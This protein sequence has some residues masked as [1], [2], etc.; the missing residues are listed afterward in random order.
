MAYRG[1][2]EFHILIA[3]SRCLVYVVAQTL[4]VFHFHG[5]HVDNIYGWVLLSVYFVALVFL[6]LLWWGAWRKRRIIKR[7]EDRFSG[8]EY[9]LG[10][11][12]TS[13]LV[14]ASSLKSAPLFINDDNDFVKFVAKE[15]LKGVPS[16]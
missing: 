16:I 7:F 5:V 2:T 3:L 4:K 9:W 6:C 13:S 15:T 10:I 14:Q 1:D 11:A 12:R 8:Q